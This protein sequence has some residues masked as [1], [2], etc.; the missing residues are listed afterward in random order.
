MID[1]TQE[2]EDMLRED[3]DPNS[4]RELDPWVFH[5]SQVGYC[6]R[7]CYVKKLGLEKL[8]GKTLGI[9]EIGTI[10]HEWFEENLPE[11]RDDVV[12]EAPI[13]TEINGIEITGHTDCVQFREGGDVVYDFKTKG[14]FYKYSGPYDRHLDQLH[15][16]MEA[17]DAPLGQIVYVS[18]KKL[19]REAQNS[20]DYWIETHPKSSALHIDRERISEVTGR[21]RDVA[22]TIERE[23]LPSEPS[24]IPYDSCGCWVCEN[25]ILDEERFF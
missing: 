18:K 9:F 20:E 8:T 4:H 15:L 19:F 10:I 2:V 21:A 1:W 5:P 16:Y 13:E 6:K 14:S 24:D 11:I 17:M 7:Q 25:T 3:E 23:G 22:E 12:M